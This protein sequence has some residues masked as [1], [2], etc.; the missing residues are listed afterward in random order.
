MF[1]SILAV[2]YFDKEVCWHIKTLRQVHVNDV[3]VQFC[4]WNVNSNQQLSSILAAYKLIKQFCKHIY[5]NWIKYAVFE[6]INGKCWVC[7]FHKFSHG[8]QGKFYLIKPND[9]ATVIAPWMT[10]W[11]IVRLGGAKRAKWNPR[12][13]Q[14][15]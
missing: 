1:N 9:Y 6:Q 4:C 3:V 13:N 11:I 8:S 15:M 10:W 2:T 7:T 14:I 12:H 5:G